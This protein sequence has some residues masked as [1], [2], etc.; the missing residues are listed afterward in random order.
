MLVRLT[1]L[2][3]MIVTLP[4]WLDAQARGPERYPEPRFQQSPDPA[5]VRQALEA[6]AR[7]MDEGRTAMGAPGL[8]WG[9]ILDGKVIAASGIGEQQSPS[10]PPVTPDSVFRIASMTKSVTALAI[11]KLRDTGRLALDEPV[12]KYVPAMAGVQPPTTD[13]PAITIRHLLTHGAGFPEDNPWGDRQLDVSVETMEG[14]LEED[15]PF[16]TPPGT[17][18]EY[19]NYGFALLGRVVAAASGTSYRSYVD[20]QIL[21]PL[22]LNASYWDS[23]DVPARQLAQG[24]RPGA[25]LERE[26][27]L[28]D[29]AFGA[30]GGLFMSGRDLGR[31]IAFMLSAWPPRDAPDEGPVRRASLREMQQFWRP[32]GFSVR[33]SAPDAP[34]Q[35]LVAAYGYGLRVTRDC[36]FQHAV[37]HGGGLPGFGSYMLWLP[38][39][40]AGV[41]VMANVTY[42]PAGG[43]ARAALDALHEAAIIAP[44]RLPASPVLISMRG[45]LTRLVN[46]WNDRDADA[47]AADNLF[48]DRSLASRRQ[49]VRGLNHDLGT[50]T[51][52]E[53]VPENWLRGRYTLQCER[54]SI[55]VSFTLSPTTP[56]QVQALSFRP[57]RRASAEVGRAARDVVELLNRWDAGRAASLLTA[58]LTPE[59][60]RRQATA[61]HV[62]YGPCRPGET[63]TR[64]GETS[65]GLRLECESGTI[66]LTLGFDPDHRLREIAFAAPADAT[67]VP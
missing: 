22:G 19:S 25:H 62:L 20:E 13:S 21:R 64:P 16:S 34:A 4:V 53:L 35:A 23:R 44:R 36:Q 12:S 46:R 49:E 60:F 30:M 6:V 43:A 40:G 41:Y 63:Q 3:P 7:L 14:W 45:R 56:P 26:D 42:A 28:P 11:L 65:A 55:D 57:A 61:L 39:Y 38:E 15:V 5:A 27:P 2:L 67:C 58:P 51:A 59:A 24:Y 9:M 50:C 18:Y 54:G 10:G 47:L 66:D 48:Q 17:H 1:Y 8:S 52:G 33:R 31:Y 29:G 32:S 37:G